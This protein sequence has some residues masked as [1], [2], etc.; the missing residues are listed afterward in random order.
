M[1]GRLSG[2]Q[3]EMAATCSRVVTH[4]GIEPP[5][6][7]R[8]RTRT[9]PVAPYNRRGGA[10]RSESGKP[11]C[12]WQS[13]RNIFQPAGMSFHAVSQK[14]KE[15]DSPAMLRPGGGRD[16]IRT[17]CRSL[18]WRLLIRMSF[19][20]MLLFLCHCEPVRTLVWQSVSP[21]KKA[22]CHV[23]ALLAMTVGRGR[24][25]QTPPI[26]LSARGGAD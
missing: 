8:L 17:R 19:L 6:G 18:C 16:G 3:K 21:D 13:H 23:A 15:G 10:P 7:P 26:Q 2:C 11:D 24:F 12:R 25:P 9:D 20:P 1:A 4:D 22:D 5:S 14:K